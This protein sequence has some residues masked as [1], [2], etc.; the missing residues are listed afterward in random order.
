MT[1]NG[2]S[3]NVLRPVVEAVIEISLK[4]DIKYEMDKQTGFLRVDRFLSTS[5]V[6][7]ANYGFI[8]NTLGGDGDPLDVLI[9][10]TPA[11]QPG[12]AIS[13]RLI[14]M[15]AMEDESGQDEKL[16]AVPVCTKEI[17][18]QHY[19]DVPELLLLKIRH[20]FEHYKDLEP[21]KWVKCL[22]WQGPDQTYDLL[23]KATKNDK[24]L[25]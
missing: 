3:C 20:F 12:S 16:L 8:P 17:Q 7:P 4:S 1:K 21:N 14:G 22:G 10:N 11:L 25:A 18:P 24:P 6:Y 23:K 5:M 13:I 19:K 2:E 9:L 15:L